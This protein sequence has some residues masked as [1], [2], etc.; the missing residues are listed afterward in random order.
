MNIMHA[1]CYLW[2]ILA[3]I[4]NVHSFLFESP[5]ENQL[6]PRTFF[7]THSQERKII[8]SVFCDG[9]DCPEFSVIKDYAYFIQERK[10]REATFLASDNRILC[11]L[12]ATV[13]AAKVTLEKYRNGD[14]VQE[15][16]IYPVAP[17]LVQ[18]DLFSSIQTSNRSCGMGFTVKMYIPPYLGIPPPPLTTSLNFVTLR[19]GFTVFVHTYA[20]PHEA[21]LFLELNDFQNALKYLHLCYKS[22]RFY[23][24]IY[25]VTG[26]ENDQRNEIWLE[27]C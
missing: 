5:L 12:N 25:E 14:N 18:I 21:R 26:N 10:Y 3:E 11:D 7:L 24:A 9:R 8:S 20:G 2:V 15:R 19:E 27:R 16:R 17:L 4:Q 23:L 6:Q 22:I 13:A 1:F